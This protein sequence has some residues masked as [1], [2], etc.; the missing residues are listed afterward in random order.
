MPEMDDAELDAI[1]DRYHI[2]EEK[3][4]QLKKQPRFNKEEDTSFVFHKIQPCLAC[5][6]NEKQQEED[7]RNR[8]NNAKQREFINN[9]VPDRLKAAGVKKIYMNA[10]LDDCKKEL[11]SFT[12]KS[13]FI[14]GDIGTGKTYSAIALLRNDFEN[15]RE[16]VFISVPNLLLKI[17]STFNN[18]KS[19]VSELELIEYYSTIPNLYLDDI[20]VEKPTEWAVQLLYVIID[21]RLCEELRTVITSNLNYQELEAH[22]GI[23]FTSRVAGM[24]GTPFKLTGTDRRLK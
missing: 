8:K 18:P 21:N 19:E 3:Y 14:Y 16:G 6:V 5:Q 23:R 22:F 11:S 13:L 20:G 10:C 7:Y 4:N 9:I 1:F 12:D 2:M 24:C 17:K 15:K